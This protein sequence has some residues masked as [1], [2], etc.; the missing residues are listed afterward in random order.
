MGR[1]IELRQNLRRLIL[2]VAVMAAAR[3]VTLA[4]LVVAGRTR[5]LSFVDVL[6]QWDGEHYLHVARHG[7]A[8]ASDQFAGTDYVGGRIAF[9]PLFPLAIRA[10][11]ALT[12]FSY[13]AAGLLVSLAASLIAAALLWLLIDDLTD[14]GATTATRAVILFAFFPGAYVMSMVY[15]EGLM[16]TFVIAAFLFLHRR[17]WLAAGAAAALATATRPNAIVL[18]ACCAW[19]AVQARD[20]K[21]WTAP[22]LAPLGAAAFHFY[23]WRHTG[24]AWAWFTVQREAWRERFDPFSIID[25]IDFYLGSPL[26]DYQGLSVIVGALLVAVGIALLV[27]D[28]APAT[29]LIWTVGVAALVFASPLLG[30]RPRFVTTAFPVFLP[31]AKR[32]SD[33]AVGATAG[34]LGMVTGWIAYVTVTSLF[35]IP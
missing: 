6:H 29:L 2:P 27:R 33:A 4:V 31:A 13:A 22:A 20:R 32:M 15:A 34:V 7:Y 8:T 21:A 17:Q 10:V 9:F 18:V 23:L 28:R 35:V 26:D 16:L 3:L 14:D 25:R 30:V 1:G 12:P 24:E 11:V 5:N 19:A